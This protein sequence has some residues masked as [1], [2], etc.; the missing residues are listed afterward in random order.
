M[1]RKTKTSR[2]VYPELWDKVSKENK[3]LLDDFMDYCRSINR[4]KT[5]IDGYYN[6][7][8]ICWVWNLQHNKNKF[9]VDFTKRDVIKYQNWL[10]TEQELSSNR[11]R[12]LRSAL[13]SLYIKGMV[14]NHRLAKAINDVSWSEFCRMIEYKAN[15]YGRTYHKINRFYASSQTCNVCGYKNVDAKDLNVRKWVCPECGTNHD[16]DNNAAINIL[17]QGLKELGLTA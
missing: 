12:R 15:W 14:Q 1:P 8:Q 7:I 13:S 10:V 4:S 3:D 17:N 6:D 5:T 16:R 9:F 2:I 11:V